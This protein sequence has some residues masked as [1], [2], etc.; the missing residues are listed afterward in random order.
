[1]DTDATE[2]MRAYEAG[3]K[4]GRKHGL[5][6]AAKLVAQASRSAEP[7]KRRAARSD[8]LSRNRGELSSAPQSRVSE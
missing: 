2:I 5:E 7:T 8:D 6:E 4:V 1:M 3:Y